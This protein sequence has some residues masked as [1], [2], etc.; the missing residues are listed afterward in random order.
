MTFFVNLTK[1][2]TT[3]G[4]RVITDRCDLHYDHKGCSD[5]FSQFDIIYDPK[6]SQGHLRSQ[7]PTGSL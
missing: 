4:C 1:F 2:M 5:L 3:I 6:M 7:S